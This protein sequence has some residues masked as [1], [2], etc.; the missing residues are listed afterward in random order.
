MPNADSPR[1]LT[2]VANLYGAPFNAAVRRFAIPA[3][4][5][6]AA[7]VGGVVKPTGTATTDG[8]MTVTSDVA[9]GEAVLGVIV[10]FDIVGPSTL[11]TQGAASTLRYPLVSVHPDALYEVQEDSVGGALAI[12][13]VGQTVSMVGLTTGSAITGVSALMLDS[14]TASAGAG[15][16]GLLIVGLVPVP[17]NEIGALAKWYVRLN[18]HFIVNATLGV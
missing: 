6:T 4:N 1:G 11:G 14:S 2:P 8:L 3:S 12:T 17:D 7:F 5:A 9:V 10:G 13:A 16:R 18:N 15:V